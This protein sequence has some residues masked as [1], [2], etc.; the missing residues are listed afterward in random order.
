MKNP[1]HEKMVEQ[2]RIEENDFACK[3]GS[4]NFRK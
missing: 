3:F 4:Q 2:K 1:L